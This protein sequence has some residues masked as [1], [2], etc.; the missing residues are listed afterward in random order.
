MH[1]F[2]KLVA[3]ALLP[4]TSVFASEWRTAVLD[5]QNIHCYAC[6]ITV[7]KALQNALG[8]EDV[9]LD[10]EKKTATVKFNPMKNITEAV[11]EATAKAGFPSTVR[12]Q[13]R[14]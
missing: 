10:I 4:V 9:T 1:S 12:R 7:K 6:L 13:A 11:V 8:I 14:N 5:L 2:T 3:L